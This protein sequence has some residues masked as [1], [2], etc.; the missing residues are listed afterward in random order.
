MVTM[1]CLDWNRLIYR[2]FVVVVFVGCFFTSHSKYRFPNNFITAFAFKNGCQLGFIL[3]GFYR[4]RKF[5]IVFKIGFIAAFF[6]VITRSYFIFKHLFYLVFML[7][8]VVLFA[9]D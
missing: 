1:F 8:K 2:L 3:H 6:V 9:G 4:L 7:D 5:P